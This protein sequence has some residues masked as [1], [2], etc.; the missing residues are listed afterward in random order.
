MLALAFGL[1]PVGLLL[2]KIADDRNLETLA[3]ERLDHHDEPEDEECETHQRT[4]EE[5]RPAEERYPADKVECNVD[6]NPA[7]AQEDRL[8]GV[9][10]D[11]GLLVEG[12]TTRKMIAGMMVM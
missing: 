7:D 4:Q 9:E 5:Q 10:A 12:G 1:L 3:V 6:H 2:G 11:D 8:P